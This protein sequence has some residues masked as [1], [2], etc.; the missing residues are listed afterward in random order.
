MHFHAVVWVD[1]RNAHVLGFG[2]GDPTRQ[3]IKSDGPEHIHHKAGS[4]DSGHLHDA[5]AYFAAIA[6]ALNDYHEILVV[7]PAETRTEF[8]TYLAGHRPDIAKKVLGIEPMAH[9]SE[10]EIIDHARRFFVHADRMT[11]Q[12]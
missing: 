3:V 12:H 8:Q 9:A 2:E 7:G 4:I 1:H 10:G 11:P 6:R 5:P